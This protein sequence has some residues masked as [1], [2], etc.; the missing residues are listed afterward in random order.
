[1]LPMRSPGDHPVSPSRSC[2]RRTHATHSSA[3]PGPGG[4]SS[5][6]RRT[7]VTRTGVPPSSAAT[8]ATSARLGPKGSGTSRTRPLVPLAPTVVQYS[9]MNGSPRGTSI[10]TLATVGVLDARDQLRVSRR[11]PAR[12]LPSL[13][14]PRAVMYGRTTVRLLRLISDSGR[15]QTA[16]ATTVTTTKALITARP[17]AVDPDAPAPPS[18]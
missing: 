16:S 18:L 17:T 13:V 11:G 3:G 2:S 9:P 7:S 15:F 4:R 8:R 10:V 14:E 5:R 12:T 6:Q 1:M